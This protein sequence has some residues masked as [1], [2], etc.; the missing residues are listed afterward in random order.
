MS[1]GTHRSRFFAD[2]LR[3]RPQKSEAPG[4]GLPPTR[5]APTNPAQ[6]HPV[7]PSRQEKPE[8]NRVEQQ[9]AG[10]VR[11]DKAHKSNT[12]RQTDAGP[13]NTLVTLPNA[14][15][16][17]TPEP[18]ADLGSTQSGRRKQQTVATGTDDGGEHTAARDEVI[19]ADSA[20][21]C[22]IAAHAEPASIRANEKIQKCNSKL[23]QVS[24]PAAE[25]EFDDQ[26][27]MA[28]NGSPSA[29]VAAEE[30]YEPL[31]TKSEVID[32]DA[33][34][35]QHSG[36]HSRDLAQP[37]ICNDQRKRADADPNKE[38]QSNMSNMSAFGRGRYKASASGS[39]L[40]VSH[41]CPSVPVENNTPASQVGSHA[42]AHSKDADITAAQLCVTPET[43]QS[44][45]SSPETRA[46]SSKALILAP[47]NLFAHFVVDS[48][49]QA[50]AISSDTPAG[51]GAVAMSTSAT[52]IAARLM[53]AERAEHL[54]AA[55]RVLLFGKDTETSADGKSGD[56]P[57]GIN[58]L[59]LQIRAQE[60]SSRFT[61][62]DLDSNK[63]DSNL[64]M[65]VT[66]K[67][68]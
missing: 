52:A 39:P 43:G 63:V 42:K 6:Q 8:A 67:P 49:H 24:R 36:L 11:F 10:S 66:L 48:S 59:W 9:R 22:S 62:M 61:R 44:Q 23:V 3:W 18:H 28:V 40:S 51:Q 32:N 14:T 58:Q 33:A 50:R 12:L 45:A 4:G 57:S 16:Q 41:K 56:P 15:H 2:M 60:L 21:H 30:M 53:S 46:G 35:F 19:I 7:V 29:L 1:K 25:M 47:K 26:P 38:L 64:S 68:H 65:Q 13:L 31:A 55:A 17:L 34:N 5:Q 20:A 27:R 54:A 37:K